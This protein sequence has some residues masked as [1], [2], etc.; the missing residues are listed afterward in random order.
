MNEYWAPSGRIPQVLR[1]T[2]PGYVPGPDGS[3]IFNP[4]APYCAPYSRS[5]GF[6][7]QKLAF[8]EQEKQSFCMYIRGYGPAIHTR[9]GSVHW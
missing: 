3:L 4:P 7:S 6:C 5:C 9:P 2:P 1:P 8:W